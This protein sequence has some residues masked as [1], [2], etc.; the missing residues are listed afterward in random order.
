[1]GTEYLE[2]IKLVEDRNEKD[3]YLHPT[4]SQD[5]DGNVLKFSVQS[6]VQFQDSD[7]SQKSDKIGCK[8]N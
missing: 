5:S 3:K 6:S 2:E 7:I 1:M 8:I 4:L